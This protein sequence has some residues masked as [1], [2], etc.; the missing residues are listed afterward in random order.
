MEALRPSETS[1]NILQTTQSHTEDET[2]FLE[3]VTHACLPHCASPPQDNNLQNNY[4]FQQNNAIVSMR[5]NFNKGQIYRGTHG[6][7]GRFQ[8]SFPPSCVPAAD[9]TSV[10]EKRKRVRIA[11]L[12]YVQRRFP[13]NSEVSSGRASGLWRH[14][15][16]FT[17]QCFTN[18]PYVVVYQTRYEAH[19]ASC[20]RGRE[21]KRQR[22]EAATYI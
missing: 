13:S 19:P 2:K 16:G 7:C 10:G 5:S 14:E 3:I 17:V 20:G 21:V 11:E 1:V 9:E 6:M 8:T 22:R 15:N 4:Y 18:I 12:T